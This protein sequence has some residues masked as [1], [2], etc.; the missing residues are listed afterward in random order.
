MI[1]VTLILVIFVA[2]D[3]K[4]SLFF[5]INVTHFM[6]L[7]IIITLCFRTTVIDDG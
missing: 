4:I 3:I 2:L 6:F 7:Y 1:I 5:V